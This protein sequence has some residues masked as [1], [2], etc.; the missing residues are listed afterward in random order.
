MESPTES[1]GAP[2][3]PGQTP[4][5]LAEENGL[6]RRV[7]MLFDEGADPADVDAMKVEALEWLNNH[8]GPSVSFSPNLFCCICD[9]TD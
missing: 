6:L 1:P 2:R 3:H 4:D 5:P 7:G 9:L 8:P